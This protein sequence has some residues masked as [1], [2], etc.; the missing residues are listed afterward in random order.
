M[1]LLGILFLSFSSGSLFPFAGAFLNY[2]NTVWYRISH[3]S[4]AGL[5]HHPGMGYFLSCFIFLTFAAL[6]LI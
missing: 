4:L 3:H 2:Q 1:V 5:F 6:S